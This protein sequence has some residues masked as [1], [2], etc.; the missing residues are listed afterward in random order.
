MLGISVMHRAGDR[1]DCA[2]Y[3]SMAA[4]ADEWIQ[5]TGKG[6]ILMA[7]DT[8]KEDDLF[9]CHAVRKLMRFPQNVEIVAHNDGTEIPMAF[10]RCGKIIGARF[11]SMVLSLRMGISFFPVIFRDKMRN[12]IQDLDYPVF[13]CEIDWIDSQAISGFLCKKQ[14]GFSLQTEYLSAANKHTQ[15]LRQK[16][17]GDC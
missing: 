4:A 2:Y 9:A 16:L 1:E 10:S 6:V 13:G 17:C 11:H 8:G 14:P 3:Q 7:F 15:L 5:K 12:L